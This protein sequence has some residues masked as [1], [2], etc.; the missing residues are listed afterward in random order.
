VPES[1]HCVAVKISFR[2]HI[3]PV[4]SS[5][6]WGSNGSVMHPYPGRACARQLSLRCCSDLIAGPPPAGFSLK[7]PCVVKQCN[8][9]IYH[10]K[11][12]EPGVQ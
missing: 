11:K 2:V 9:S 12:G 5:K 3:G 6:H 4:S 1:C 7:T 8:A 10:D